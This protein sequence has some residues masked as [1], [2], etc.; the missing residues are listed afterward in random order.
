MPPPLPAN[1]PSPRPPLAEQCVKDEATG[2]DRR[3]SVFFPKVCVGA[4]TRAGGDYELRQVAA[5]A[6]HPG[7]AGT[8]K[9]KQAFFNNVALLLLDKPSTKRWATLPPFTRAPGRA[10]MGCCRALAGPGPASDAQPTRCPADPPP[11]GA[12]LQRNRRWPDRQAA[13]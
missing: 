4:H 9:A 1:A 12:R 8:D 2:A 13:C 7:F 5:T 6:A 3:D 10:L 11:T